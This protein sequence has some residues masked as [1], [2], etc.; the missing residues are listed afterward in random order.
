MIGAPT[1]EAFKSGDLNERQPRQAWNYG[2]WRC[3]DN[4]EGLLEDSGIVATFDLTDQWK[5][6]KPLTN[7][8]AL[9]LA[10]ERTPGAGVRLS[11]NPVDIG[12][13]FA[14]QNHAKLL[15]GDVNYSHKNWYFAVMVTG[16]T[17]EEITQSL[18][19][20]IQESD[21]SL[22]DQPTVFVHEQ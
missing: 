4:G 16:A 2:V 20:L 21:Q 8:E 18:L 11:A 22:L 12:G 17:P 13:D 5:R 10:A 14:S 1:A 7:I 9:R 15:E 6:T 19:E 3:F